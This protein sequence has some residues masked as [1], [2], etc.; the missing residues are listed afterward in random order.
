[1]KYANH[2]NIGILNVFIAETSRRISR[3]LH[4]HEAH[5][6]EFLPRVSNGTT[7]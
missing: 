6:Y 4:I 3:C 2:K 5:G 7:P 1:M